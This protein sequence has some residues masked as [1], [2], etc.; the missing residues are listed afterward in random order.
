MGHIEINLLRDDNVIETLDVY[1]LLIDGKFNL[2]K[3]LRSECIYVSARK[4]LHQ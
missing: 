2:K 4:I 1:D 3:R